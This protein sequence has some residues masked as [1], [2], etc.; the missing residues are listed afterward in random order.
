MI[1]LIGFHFMTYYYLIDSLKKYIQKIV[2]VYKLRRREK[3]R[4]VIYV[5]VKV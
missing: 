5:V 4:K 2:K 3:A 1:D